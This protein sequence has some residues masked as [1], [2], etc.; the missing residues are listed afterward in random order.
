MPRHFNNLS[1]FIN[2]F[3]SPRRARTPYRDPSRRNATSAFIRGTHSLSSVSTD[4]ERPVRF[5]QKFRGAF[6][7]RRM[8]SR[9]SRSESSNRGLQPWLLADRERNAPRRAG[10]NAALGVSRPPSRSPRGL[11]RLFSLHPGVPKFFSSLLH[12]PRAAFERSLLRR[13]SASKGET[14]RARGAGERG[15]GGT[16][17]RGR[18]AR[19]GPERAAERRECR[20]ERKR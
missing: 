18:G 16:R 20:R 10:V 3:S 12:A 11:L 6:F 8:A 19:E 15:K 4:G 2:F 7:S 13:R 1:N 14:A 5:G 9:R 17:G